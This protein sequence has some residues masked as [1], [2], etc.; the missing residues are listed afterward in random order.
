V[1]CISLF[2]LLKLQTVVEGVL[3]TLYNIEQAQGDFFQP[4]L[5]TVPAQHPA[6]T[7]HSKQQELID[8]E[9][10]SA[11]LMVR[12]FQVWHNWKPATTYRKVTFYKL[13]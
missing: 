9:R 13:P 12:Y 6:C 5:A 11:R 2:W 1:L 10:L 7:L 8:R 4:A 3:V